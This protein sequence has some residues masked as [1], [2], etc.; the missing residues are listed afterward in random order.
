MLQFLKYVLATLVGLCLFFFLGFVIMLSIIAAAS[1]DKKETISDN[2]IL[3]LKLDRPIVERESNDPFAEFGFSFGNLRSSIGL[4]ELKEAIRKA[5]ADDNIKGIY[6]NVDLLDAG[7]ATVEEIR[8]E[9]IEFKKSGK[10]VVTYSEICNEKS[11]YLASISDKLY[12]N[13]GGALELNGLSSEIL[14]FK[15]TLEKLDIKPY[16][17]KVGEFK[18]AVEPFVLDKMSEANREQTKSFLTSINGYMLQNIAKA[19]GKTVEELRTISDSMLVHNAE[20]AL[21]YGLVTDL[22]YYDEAV[23]FMRG[24]TN[25]TDK[26]DLNLVKL[27][28]YKKVESNIKKGSSKNKIAVVYGSGNIV[29]GKGGADNIGGESMSEA[30]REA[31]EDENVKAVVLRINS[32]GGSALASDVIWREVMLTRK[33][34]PVI[35]SMSDVAASGGYYIAMACD[36]IVAHP[37]TITGSIG[38]FGI[39]GNIEHFLNNK[40][41]IT[42]DRVKTGYFSDVPTITREMTPFEK[43]VIQKQVERIYDEFTKKAAEGRDMTQEQLKQYASGRVWSGIEAKER[44]LVDVHGGLEEAIAIAAAR[45]GLK[46]DQY[47]V[48]ELPKQKS[49]LE[50]I[51]TDWSEEMERSAIQKELNAFYPQLRLLQELKEMEGVQARMPYDL[52]IR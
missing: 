19:R 37:N 10:W 20:D 40:L 49:F 22:G 33:V 34:K 43:Q 23:A 41:G 47:R 2:S 3:E 31:R 28:T 45:A 1:A 51:L 50:S 27:K 18:S 9:L 14:F 16:I 38:V 52:I 21:K 26:D 5:K 17:F 30:I 12:L 4:T 13:P 35:A 44:G 7:M 25:I 24:K 29:N 42:V 36:T 32:P 6:L 48:K 46:Q 8:N 39:L 11:Y 15:G